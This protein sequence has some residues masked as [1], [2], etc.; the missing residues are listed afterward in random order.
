[1][2]NMELLLQKT[3]ADITKS[4]VLPLI[5]GAL[6]SDSL[7]VQEQCLSIIPSF[8]SLIDYP[9]MK[10]SLLPRIRKL[11]VS[12]P[13]LSVS[14]S[15]IYNMHATRLTVISH[16]EFNLN[17]INIKERFNGCVQVRV[18]CLVCTGKI[19]DHMDKWLVIDFVLPFLIEVPSR[20]SAVI[21]AILGE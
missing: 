2:K 15:P 19:M 20:E 13:T 16:H 1:M 7:Q 10:N 14:A 8:V 3:P 9:A 18:N 5:Y 6:E 12:T 11:C 4:D 21:M 17:R